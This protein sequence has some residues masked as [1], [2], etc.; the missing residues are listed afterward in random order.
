[1]SKYNRV[2]LRRCSR[3]LDILSWLIAG[4]S[5]IQS[6]GGFF[7][8][9]SYRDGTRVLTT[10]RGNDLVTLSIACP[11]LIAALVGAERDRKRA[12]LLRVS[13]LFYMF[14]NYS[15]FV[16]GAAVNRFFLIYVSIFAMAA[17]GLVLAVVFTVHPSEMH[18]NQ[19][20]NKFA[21]S[22]MMLMALIVAATW[23][24]QWLAF[25]LSGKPPQLA[26][27]VNA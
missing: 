15:F 6:A 10:W 2:L 25:V 12:Y 19:L 13:M 11:L 18:G 9:Q 27:D 21:S 3:E 24:I 16:F 14:Y 1:M 8:S 22:F 26:G 20:V 7:V 5:V 4:F 23:I 17:Y